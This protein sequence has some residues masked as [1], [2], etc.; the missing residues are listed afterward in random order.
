MANVDQLQAP[1]PQHNGEKLERA[2]RQVAA[3]KGFYVH[4]FVFV[5]VVAVLMLVDA[6]TG[7]RWWVH[8]VFLGW[9]IG[10]VAHALAVFG[11]TSRAVADWEERKVKELMQR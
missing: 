11:R 10:V 2:K 1:A 6:A 9:G 7:E 4:L 5:V 8:W 3:M